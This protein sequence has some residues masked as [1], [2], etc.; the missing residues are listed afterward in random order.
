[1]H[2][3]PSLSRNSSSTTVVPFLFL[4]LYSRVNFNSLSLRVLTPSKIDHSSSIPIF[5]LSIFTFLLPCKEEGVE[6]PAFLDKVLSVHSFPPHLPY[7][8]TKPICSF[9]PSL[10][11]FSAIYYFPLLEQ[12]MYLSMTLLHTSVFPELLTQ[13]MYMAW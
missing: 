11:Q 13:F 10:P 5:L 12:S 9:V 7:P 2:L 8:F 1:M 6:P 4:L 3:F